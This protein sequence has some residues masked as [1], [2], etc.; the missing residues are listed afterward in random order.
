MRIFGRHRTHDEKEIRAATVATEKSAQEADEDVAI[1]RGRLAEERE[2]I[3]PVLKRL[4][5][6]NHVADA[7]I[8]VIETSRKK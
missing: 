2:S 8:Y 1:Q 5:E 7:L 3:I 4:H 6:Q